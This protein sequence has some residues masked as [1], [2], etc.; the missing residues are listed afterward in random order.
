[1]P[2]KSRLNKLI[3]AFTNQM[4]EACCLFLDA[5]LLVLTSL[6]LMLQRADHV[7]H[8]MFE[9]LFE[10]ATIL[11]S[12]FA[13]PTVVQEVKNGKLFKCQK[14]LTKYLDDPVNHLPTDKLY[15]GYLARSNVDK[16]LDDGDIDKNEN[17]QFFMAVCV[18]I[19]EHLFMQW[20]TFH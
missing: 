8:L 16:L 10:C 7:I 3:D 17:S 11:L 9:A 1:M 19:K 13:L 12:R 20:K 6:N 18:S 2:E 14:D 4:T 15:V 5:A